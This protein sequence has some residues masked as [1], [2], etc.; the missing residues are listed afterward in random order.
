MKRKASS[1]HRDPLEAEIQHAAYLLWIE[2][3]RPDGC[4]LEHWLAAKELLCRRH[5]RDATTGRRA[6][7]VAAPT[8]QR[9]GGR[10]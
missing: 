7:E 3:G 8:R 1:H 2:S 10:N 4:D 6:I 5:G 9:T